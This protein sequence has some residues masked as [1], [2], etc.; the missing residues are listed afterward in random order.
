MRVAD[1]YWAK[2]D[3]PA[4]EDYYDKYCREFP[5]GPSVR[6]AELLRAKCTIESCRG[7]RYDTSSLQLAYD[8]LNQFLKKYPEEARQENVAALMDSVR[9]MQAQGLYE[10]AV[11]YQRAGKPQA[12]AYYADRL[13]E[14]FPDSVWSRAGRADAGG[15][16]RQGGAQ[17]VTT[18]RGWLVVAAAAALVAARLRVLHAAAAP[19]GRQDRVGVDLRL[20]GV[21]ARTGIRPDGQTGAPDR[22]R[23]RRT[24]SCT[25]R[26]G[27]TRNCA[28]RSSCSTRRS[29][30]RTPTTNQPQDIAVTR[31]LL[32]RVEGPEDG[33]DP[34]PARRSAARPRMRRP[35]ART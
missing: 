11:Q 16:A 25:T 9:D 20:Q 4:A 5:N 12:A 18:A 10:T 6:R 3:W 31:H 1:Y 34:G 30:P 22:A 14:R 33:R 32:V 23:G 13:R 8:R 27:P 35:S 17:A 26:S 2:R 21:P 24:R 19:D 15:K 28:A 29:S 7:P